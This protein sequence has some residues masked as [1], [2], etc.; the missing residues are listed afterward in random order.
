MI[1]HIAA[2]GLNLG[3][4]KNFGFNTIFVLIGQLIDIAMYLVGALSV[5][6]LIIGGLRYSLSAGDPKNLQQ[7][8]QTIWYA[9]MGLVIAILAVAIKTYAGGIFT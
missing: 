9:V 8:K 1:Q 5:I 3:D 2:L 6:F 7:A 4:P